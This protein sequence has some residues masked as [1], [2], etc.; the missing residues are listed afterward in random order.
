MSNIIEPSTTL[1]DF[2]I[3]RVIGKGSFGSVFLVKRKLDQKLYALKSVFLDKLNKKEQENSVNEVRLLASVSHPNVISYKE[4]FFDEKNY[5]LN[6]IME[7]ADNGDLQ[8]EINKKKKELDTFD[9][10]IIW[11]YSIQM[12]EGLKALHDKKIMHR[13]L[14]SANIFLSKNKFQCKLGDM[15]VSKVIKEKVL[16]TQTGTPYYASPEVW[17]DEPYSYKSD[18]W[19]IGCVIYEMCA[20]EPPF[21]GKDLDE[22]FENVCRGKLKRIN[23]RY[24]EDLWNM[25]L[26]LLQN[27]VEKRVNCDEFLES[28]L[29]K[30]KINELKNNPEINYEAYLLEKNIGLKNENDVLLQTIKFKNFN[31]LKNNLPSLKNYENNF[32]KRT[33][34]N[35]KSNSNSLYK[36]KN[37]S[38]DAIIINN[39]SKNINHSMNNIKE[40][41][42]SKKR[43]IHKN[44]SFSKENENPNHFTQIN[45]NNLEE[46]S[47]IKI[48]TKK[49]FTNLKLKKN[50][51]MRGKKHPSYILIPTNEKKGKKVFKDFEKIMEL[52]KIKE[53]LK[54]NRKKERSIIKTERSKNELYKK[55]LSNLLRNQ[56]DNNRKKFVKKININN[57][58]KLIKPKSKKNYINPNKIPNLVKR[59]NTEQK[60]SILNKIYKLNFSKIIQ[61]KLIKSPTSLSIKLNS[62]KERAHSHNVLRIKKAIH[63]KNKL[64]HIYSNIFTNINLSTN[65]RKNKKF[66][67]KNKMPLIIP[68]LINKGKSKSKSK[69]RNLT[70]IP[71]NQDSNNNNNIISIKKGKNRLL[72]EVF[73]TINLNQNKRAKTNNKIIYKNKIIS[74]KDKRAFSSQNKKLLKEGLNENSTNTDNNINTISNIHNNSIFEENNIN[75][76]KNL[77]N[78]KNYSIIMNKGYT[79][80]QHSKEE[81]NNKNN[82]NNININESDYI[83]FNLN[84]SKKNIKQKT[85]QNQKIINDSYIPMSFRQRT[86]NNSIGSS[87]NKSNIELIQKKNY[88]KCNLNKIKKK[89]NP[90]N[91]NI[92]KLNIPRFY[93]IDKNNNNFL[94]Y[95][96]HFNSQKNMFDFDNNNFIKSNREK[97]N[98]NLTKNK[99]VLNISE[100]NNYIISNPN[101]FLQNMKPIYLDIKN[102]DHLNILYKKKLKLIKNNKR[103]N[104]S[105]SGCNLKKE[106]TIKSQ[107]FNNFFSIN[108]FD[109]KHPVRVI[110]FYN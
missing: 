76:K 9:E 12:I 70:T 45:N 48:H 68:Y 46:N 64:K 38:L 77:F 82:N 37:N 56:T 20:L 63:V 29:I 105:S 41:A 34:N 32:N 107:I 23:I 27:D 28:E 90:K 11:L 49:N 17:R 50:N 40:K 3:E 57:S 96:R 79:H 6:I 30:K 36:S 61:K 98:L 78:F 33:I 67:I 31:E 106:K 86:L 110:N 84:L 80:K 65:T 101:T 47:F 87:I 52:K 83:I 8:T 89:N 16:T 43:I 72:N 55:S 25:I 104:T 93:R 102:N 95:K 75:K 26:M 94:E 5:S 103:I 44:I 91:I 14:K 99:N 62:N 71:Y 35:S 1:N 66:I 24:S 60:K 13:D 2:T 15:N 42:C 19:S 92:K 18:L 59:V 73:N 58:S 109:S 10:N 74:I 21:N 100:S 108:N 69:K 7:Y 88:I 81:K 53:Y 54:I 85:L 39:Y 22:L 4:S 51:S 97:N